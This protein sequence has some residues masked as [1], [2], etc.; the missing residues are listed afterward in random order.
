MAMEKGVFQR[1]VKRPED[2]LADERRGQREI[3][4]GQ[5]LGQ[6][7]HV[8]GD[9]LSVKGHRRAGSAKCRE[10]LIQENLGPNLAGGLTG[11]LRVPLRMHDHPRRP[12]DTGLQYPGSQ[13]LPAS[14]DLFLGL[15][16]ALK[17]AL[18]IGTGVSFFWLGPIVAA[19]VAKRRHHPARREKKRLVMAVKVVARAEAHGTD[20]VPMVSAF[21]GDEL[22]SLRLPCLGE[23]LHNHFQA[24]FHGG[25]AVIGKK[26]TVQTRISMR[27]NEGE[28]FLGQLG[29]RFMSQA[30]K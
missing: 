1:T 3:S 7:D 9:P 20:G 22:S 24:G 4:A 15:G 5:T 26:D 16:G 25:G 2:F 8:R 23:G 14:G 28:Q 11:P 19:A 18:P 30:E 27:L 13:V 6:S 21:G 12:L 29:G 17:V 10:H